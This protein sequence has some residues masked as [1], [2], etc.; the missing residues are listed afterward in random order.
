MIFPFQTK[1]IKNPYKIKPIYYTYLNT[2]FYQ[3]RTYTYRTLSYDRFLKLIAYSQN[4]IF[5]KTYF[6][7]KN[8]TTIIYIASSFPNQDGNI[9]NVVEIINN[10][11]KSLKKTYIYKNQTRI[12]SNQFN[13]LLF[14]YYD[15]INLPDR[16]YFVE[17]LKIRIEHQ[18][19]SESKK[20]KLKYILDQSI[21]N[22]DFIYIVKPKLEYMPASSHPS[23]FVFDLICIQPQ[24]GHFK[25]I[26]ALTDFLGN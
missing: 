24:K 10:D 22:K 7:P 20:Q 26:G 18:N 12:K 25:I 16:K 19:F 17:D 6:T 23:I 11:F 9:K 21:K 8:L 5:L 3:N 2:Y 14:T 13:I 1:E 15:P 4:R